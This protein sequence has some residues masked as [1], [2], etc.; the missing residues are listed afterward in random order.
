MAFDISTEGGCMAEN[1]DYLARWIAEG[2]DTPRFEPADVCALTGISSQSL[3]NWANRSLISP[4][5]SRPGKGGRRLYDKFDVCVIAIARGLIQLGMEASAAL[6]LAA[7]II[8]KFAAKLAELDFKLSD[9]EFVRVMAWVFVDQ[10]GRRQTL[11][12]I[13]R[14]QTIREEEVAPM[15]VASESLD[16]G[17]GKKL[18]DIYKAV[19]YLEH[20]K[21]G[22]T[23]PE[24]AEPTATSH[25]N[26]KKTPAAKV[27]AS[28]PRSTKSK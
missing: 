5:A 20:E 26:D 11:I 25:L 2:I 23:Q 22:R 21:S 16:I 6:N 27:R 13:P 12:V 14:D 3:Q 18:W 15:K 9:R 24:T 8:M 1:Y 10:L 17:L 4:E 19:T 28:K 7:E